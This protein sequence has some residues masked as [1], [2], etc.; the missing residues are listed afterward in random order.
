MGL[1]FNIQEFSLNDGPGIRTSVFFK[2]CNLRCF[3]CHNPESWE[4]REQIQFFANKCIGC[5]ACSDVCDIGGAVT[6]S[7]FTRDCKSCGKCAGVCFTEA[8]VKTGYHV[9]VRELFDKIMQSKDIFDSS[10]GGVTFTGGE[11][12]MQSDFLFDILK[13]CKND[14]IH[15]AVETALH[16]DE[17]AVKTL[18]E[19]ADMIF[20]DIKTMDSKKH[21]KAT[22]VSNARILAN[23]KSI[24]STAPQKLS[25]RT[26]V[27]PGF[28]DTASDIAEI[29]RFVKSV[30]AGEVTLELLPF[31]GYC[32]GKYASLGK[33]YA[34]AGLQT[35]DEETMRRL[36]DVASEILMK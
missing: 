7:F 35:P 21:I 5:G 15:T 14:N 10:G 4:M 23:V 9:T 17:T 12:L 25:V 27:I 24:A 36:G 2:G 8:I 6:E 22:G 31:H 13:L 32:V 28:N 26:P 34:A 3:W 16:A 20:C 18:T 11:P 29:A 19:L 30:G 1:V 33:V